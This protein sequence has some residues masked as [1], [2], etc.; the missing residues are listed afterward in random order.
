M[1]ALGNRGTA[2]K[3]FDKQND[4]RWRHRIFLLSARQ[5]KG[6]AGKELHRHA[7]LLSRLRLV[8]AIQDVQQIFRNAKNTISSYAG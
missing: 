8:R 6:D 4:G 5:E 7:H 1:P 2:R 3:G